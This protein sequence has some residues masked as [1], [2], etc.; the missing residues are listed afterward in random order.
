MISKLVAPLGIEAEPTWDRSHTSSTIT[1]PV[2]GDLYSLRSHEAN[3][4]CH[5][6]ATA[7]SAEALHVAYLVI[8]DAIHV[9]FVQAE[10]GVIDEEL[11]DVLVPV[12]ENFTSNIGLVCE[13]QAEILVSRGLEIEE[14]DAL[15]I[16]AERRTGMVVNQ[17]EKH[18]DAVEMQNIDEALEL[19]GTGRQL[20]KGKRILAVCRKQR[21]G[22]RKVPGK[23][24]RI[25]NFICHLG[26]LEVEIVVAEAGF[27][28]EF[29]DGKELNGVDAKV[30]EVIDAVQ[31]VKKAAD[32]RALIL[33]RRIHPIKRADVQLVQDVVVEGGRLK[34][35]VVPWKGVRRANQAIAIW[36]RRINAEFARTWV[37]LEAECCLTD[38][39]ESVGITLF[40]TGDKPAPGVVSPVEKLLGTGRN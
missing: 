18:R 31:N 20:A 5:V 39:P 24:L 30:A 14:V 17:I 23:I 32:F 35:L 33:A 28:W 4:A 26:R 9:A 3:G 36:I 7:A 37:A 25:L 21:V 34:A 13:I 8:A 15:R 22:L 12:G 10:H 11:P 29:L 2:F 27:R 38:Y 16:K 6:L 19:V 1:V 40:E